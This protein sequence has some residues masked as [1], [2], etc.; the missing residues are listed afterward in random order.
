[1]A[2]NMKKAA[3]DPINLIS[4]GSGA[5]KEGINSVPGG[6]FGNSKDAG[7]LGTGQFKGQ[8]VDI[9]GGAF[10]DTAKQD[11]LG[12]SF[13]QALAASQARQAGQVQGAQLGP[14]RE[15]QGAVIDK[16]QQ[17]QFRGQQMS[18]A[19]ALNQQAMGNGPSLAQS[20][21]RQATEGNI[22]NALAMAASQRGGNPALAQRN[23]AMNVAAANQQ[24]AAQSADLRAQEQMAARG[25]LGQVL[26]SGRGQDIGLAQGQAELNQGA[27]LANQSAVNQFSITGAQL[28]QQA[29]LANQQAALQQQA[30]ND[31][32]A[33]FYQ[34]QQADMLDKQKAAQMA[35]ETLKVNQNSALQGA[36]AQGYANASQARG[37]LIGGI[38]SGIAAMSDEELK[39]DKKDASTDLQKFLSSFSSSEATSASDPNK[40]KGQQE[41][42]KAI[43]GGVG[44][45]M[46]GSPAAAG[47]GEAMAGEAA[48][49]GA[50]AFASKGGV[51]PGEAEV[52]GD[53]P[54]NDKVPVMASPGEVIVPRTAA[55]DPEKLQSFVDA[56]SA[57]SYK[58]KDKKHGDGTYVSP[59]AQELEKSELGKHMVID[60][61]EGKMVN[62]ARAGGT[63][64][65]TAA[66]LNDRMTELEKAFKS[67]AEKKGAA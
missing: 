60:T 42:G 67:R 13:A 18:L 38:G 63:M 23:A 39:K 33:R 43:G 66:M 59:M 2:F 27:N 65:A 28:Q 54:K 9:N 7:I 41:T 48:P 51:V 40:Y 17:D 53:S 61:P 58:Y 50:M 12:G 8:G 31:A 47:G 19:D 52:E 6:L 46:K 11:A 21:L 62:Y 15:I 56:L 3:L 32:Q 4:P 49:M 5:I 14:A 16:S 55:K 37:N 1:M 24:A 22:A 26:S 10:T 35:L 36:N 44:K 57:T 29:N 64:L 45:L 34:G 20:Q 30:Q 25:Q